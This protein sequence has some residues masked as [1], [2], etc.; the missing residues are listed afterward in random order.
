MDVC[1]VSDHV[2]AH[3]SGV[4]WSVLY[5]VVRPGEQPATDAKPEDTAQTTETGLVYHVVELH[6]GGDVCP[7]APQVTLSVSGGESATAADAKSVVAATHATR[8]A[9]TLTPPTP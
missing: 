3:A 1:W 7:V 4:F 6:A 5:T 8:V 2:T 9:R